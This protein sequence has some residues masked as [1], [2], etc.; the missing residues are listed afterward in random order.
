MAVWLQ[1]RS[2]GHA[3]RV[4]LAGDALTCCR[5]PPPLSGPLPETT[6][7]H[8]P[9]QGGQPTQVLVTVCDSLRPSMPF[10]LA[11]PWDICVHVPVPPGTSGA[12]RGFPQDWAF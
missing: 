9:P 12:G 5:A 4:L 7:S 2:V 11:G 8:A 6:P 1:G 10:C 3:W